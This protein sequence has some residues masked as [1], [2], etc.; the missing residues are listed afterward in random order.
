ME[1]KTSDAQ[2]AK[3][4]GGIRWPV[5]SIVAAVVAVLVFAGGALAANFLAAPPRGGEGGFFNGQRPN[6]QIQAAKELP[7]EAATLQGVVTNR[8]GN[9]LSVGQRNGGFAPGG[10]TSGNTNLVDVI[11][12]SNTTLYHDTTQ[13]NFSREQPPSGPIQQTVEPGK[14]D[15]IGTNSRVTVWGTQTGNQLT[16]KVLVYTDPQGFR[17]PQ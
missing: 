16:A 11:V 6:F 2:P 15:A 8:T 4:P 9:S 14:V 12:D 1:Q 3:K 13:M 7:A 10:N 5:V 17:P